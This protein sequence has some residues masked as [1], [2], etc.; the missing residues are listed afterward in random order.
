M[1]GAER[2]DADR[3]RITLLQH[4]REHLAGMRCEL[5]RPIGEPVEAGR[6]PQL[7]VG[8]DRDAR[9]APAN[10]IGLCLGA[11]DG[12]GA[13]CQDGDDRARMVRPGGGRVS[14]E[15]GNGALAR[16]NERIA[17]GIRQAGAKERVAAS[18]LCAKAFEVG[19]LNNPYFLLH[20]CA[21]FLALLS[22]LSLDKRG[23]D[24]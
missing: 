2:V 18:Q 4:G 16:G 24:E 8:M 22:I 7:D 9:H 15:V 17:T 13:R 21:R 1:H 19:Q 20:R 5:D 3:A 12:E 14:G 23:N 11:D 10:G 6:Q